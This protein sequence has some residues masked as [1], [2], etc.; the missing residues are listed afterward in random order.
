MRQSVEIADWMICASVAR[1][2][3]K[4]LE[5]RFQRLIAPGIP[6]GAAGAHTVSQTER[7]R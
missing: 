1:Y 2:L 4:R 7:G 5:Y 3:R 6:H